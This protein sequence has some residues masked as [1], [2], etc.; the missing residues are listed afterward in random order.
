MFP[1]CRQRE[2][3]VRERWMP[4]TRKASATILRHAV[5]AINHEGISADVA[6]LGRDEKGDRRATFSVDRNEKRCPPPAAI[7]ARFS[8][9]S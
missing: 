3:G 5:A 4:G 2:E 8:P 1:E 7:P 6:G 9:R